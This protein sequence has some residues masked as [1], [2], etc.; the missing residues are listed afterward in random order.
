MEN[1]IG[2][3]VALNMTVVMS[4]EFVEATLLRLVSG[5]F[6]QVPLAEQS[7]SVTVSPTG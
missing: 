6:P 2:K 7:G 3:V 5:I 1:L 4:K